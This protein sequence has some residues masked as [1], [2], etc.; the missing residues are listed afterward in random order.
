M[1]PSSAWCGCHVGDS[2][3]CHVYRVRFAA[4][5]VKCHRYFHSAALRNV[6]GT[7]PSQTLPTPA[8]APVTTHANG[9]PSPHADYT[10]LPLTIPYRLAAKRSATWTG[11]GPSTPGI[12]R[13]RTGYH[14]HTRNT[15]MPVGVGVG[16]VR[17]SIVKASLSPVML[18]SNACGTGCGAMSAYGSGVTSV[19]GA[20]RASTNTGATSAPSQTRRRRNGCR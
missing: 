6:T 1:P 7:Q 20:Q 2:C 10:R 3:R 18:Q 15:R 4:V 8:G 9:S 11:H 5:N 16:G 14:R 19:T 12:D 13:K 17:Q